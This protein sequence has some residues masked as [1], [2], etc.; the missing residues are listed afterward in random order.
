[1][2]LSLYERDTVPAAITLPKMRTSCAAL[3]IAGELQPQYAA[4]I[5]SS[6]NSGRKTASMQR[7]TSVVPFSR[8][9]T[10]HGGP[11]QEQSKLKLKAKQAARQLLQALAHPVEA[12]S[13]IRAGEPLL[14]PSAASHAGTSNSATERPAG[15]HTETRGGLETDDAEESV[16]SIVEQDMWQVVE[17]IRVELA[18]AVTS[19]ECLGATQT[20][21]ARAQAALGA[22]R[23]S[24][25]R[26]EGILQAVL[27][28]CT[29]DAQ[30]SAAASVNSCHAALRLCHRLT[31]DVQAPAL[32]PA[33]EA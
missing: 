28:L 32:C 16:T 14:M 27:R 5:S 17:L 6:K 20:A 15:G 22:G 19:A 9:D 29:Q 33:W 30:V 13:R 25:G 26:A 7:T 8:N 21:F 31:T 23:G 24:G 1:V 12:V 4:S 2:P 3:P 18:A 11:R 10:Q